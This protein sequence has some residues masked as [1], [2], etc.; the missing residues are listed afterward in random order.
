MEDQNQSKTENCSR[1]VRAKG[2][3]RVHYQ[4]WRKGAYG[5]TRYKSCKA[6]GCTARRYQKAYCEEHFNSVFLKKA[7]GE[8]AA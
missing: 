4:R 5:K 2:Y 8:S 6:E 7:A 1:P 3:C